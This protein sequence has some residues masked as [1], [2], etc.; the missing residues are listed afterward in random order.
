MQLVLPAQRGSMNCSRTSAS[1]IVKV[2]RSARSSPFAPT[3]TLPAPG[4]TDQFQG[5]P[6]TVHQPP[7]SALPQP[8]ATVRWKLSAAGL[9]EALVVL[10]RSS[11]PSE[12]PPAFVAT[13]RKWYSVPSLRP[14]IAA[15]TALI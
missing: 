12:V 10:K 1:W 3:V 14:L 8:L 7:V 4:A 6:T 13:I 9:V 5:E 2:D 15:G 11:A